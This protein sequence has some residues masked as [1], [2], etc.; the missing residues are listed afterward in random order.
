[1]LNFWSPTLVQT[2][3]FIHY[4]ISGQREY[5][6][7]W[8]AFRRTHCKP[9]S[10]PVLWIWSLIATAKSRSAENKEHHWL[11]NL[12]DFR[13]QSARIASSPTTSSYCP[14]GKRDALNSWLIRRRR[15]MCKCRPLFLKLRWCFQQVFNLSSFLSVC[16]SHRYSWVMSSSFPWECLSLLSSILHIQGKEYTDFKSTINGSS[17]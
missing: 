4:Y 15:L 2:Y 8:C 11:Y 16:L 13:W 14:C 7:G 17:Y 10:P 6:N 3:L 1:M 9:R 12:C 5:G